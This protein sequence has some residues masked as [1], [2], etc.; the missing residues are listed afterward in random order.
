MK[1]SLM[2]RD[3][4]T[5]SRE[6]SGIFETIFPYLIPGVVANINKLA[7]PCPGVM[8]VSAALLQE[9]KLQKAMLFQIALSITEL[10][11]RS[12]KQ[13]DWTDIL[14]HAVSKQRFYYDAA[15]P[16]EVSEIDKKIATTVSENLIRMLVTFAKKKGKGIE[17]IVI[18]PQIP[19]YNWISSGHGDF[20]LERT[21]IEVKCSG[22][23][24]SS[25]DYRQ[26]LMYWLMSYLHAIET[27]EDEWKNCLMLNPRLNRFTEIDFDSLIKVT[28][29]GGSKVELLELFRAAI[30]FNQ[31][32]S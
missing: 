14:E 11:L 17:D 4:R 22:K 2:G 26:I 13:P 31:N 20:A 12:P 3:P 18:A 30:D 27:G 7:A 15:L 25:A 28:S 10:K 6:I 29:P 16:E 5:V 21:L 9:S 1:S 19:G 32:I 24:F 23:N 8:L